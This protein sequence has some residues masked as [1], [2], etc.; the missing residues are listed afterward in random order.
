MT[1]DQPYQLSS[2]AGQRSTKCEFQRPALVFAV[3]NSDAE[4]RLRLSP[5]ANKTQSD[6]HGR[7]RRPKTPVNKLSCAD[8][9]PH[10]RDSVLGCLVLDDER[11]RRPAHNRSRG[12]PAVGPASRR[13]RLQDDDGWGAA[14]LLVGSIIQLPAAEADDREK[15]PTSVTIVTALIKATPRIA[16]I[17]V[18]TGAIDRLGRCS[19]IC[20]VSRSTRR[21]ASVTAS[22]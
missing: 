7:R 12:F 22:M 16:W 5:N 20:R 19:V 14:L 21:S 2:K 1:L 15:S 9:L 10:D 11:R 4:S 6:A 13:R 17:A 8:W 18:A 3:K